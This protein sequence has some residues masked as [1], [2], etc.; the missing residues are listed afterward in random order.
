MNKLNIYEFIE[1]VKQNELK[2][3][4]YCEV[5]IGPYGNIIE[6]IPSHTET[7]IAYA[8]EKE[9]KSRKDIGYLPKL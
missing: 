6:A 1:H 9:N 5:I 8:M 3:I 7:V 4:N 2:Y